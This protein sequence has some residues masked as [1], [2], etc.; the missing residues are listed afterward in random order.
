MWFYMQVA[1]IRNENDKVVLFLCT[2]KD[3]TVFK[4]PIEDDTTTG[5]WPAGL[6]FCR[7]VSD[8]SLQLSLCRLYGSCMC[9]TAFRET[10]M[11]IFRISLRISGSS[12]CRQSTGVD[13]SCH[14]NYTL[15]LVMSQMAVIG[16]DSFTIHLLAK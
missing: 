5:E 16:D 11:N 8:A 10:T 7:C 9:Y 2:F 14:S 13:S 6:R 12:W 1:P 15:P 4:Q 3:I